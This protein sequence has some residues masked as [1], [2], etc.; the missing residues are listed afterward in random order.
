MITTFWTDGYR[1][2]WRDVAPCTEA[3]YSCKAYW[4]EYEAGYHAGRFALECH[5]CD[6]DGNRLKERIGR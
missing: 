4:L 1:D 6:L 2:G 3:D 5:G